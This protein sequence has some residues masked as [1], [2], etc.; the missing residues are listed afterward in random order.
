MFD[1][2]LYPP[3]I[4]FPFDDTVA[5]AEAT[6]TGVTSTND[7]GGDPDDNEPDPKSILD[8][9]KEAV[10]GQ[11]DFIETRKDV[12]KD[13]EEHLL[14]IQSDRKEHQKLLDYYNEGKCQ[15][16]DRCCLYIYSSPDLLS[17]YLLKKH[18]QVT[19]INEKKKQHACGKNAKRSKQKLCQRELIILWRLMINTI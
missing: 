11:K 4:L 5:H 3:L 13:Y 2:N 19:Q 15:G 8:A 12:L 16:S 14:D 7:S 17:L 18:S 6:S 1:Q 9:A 10:K